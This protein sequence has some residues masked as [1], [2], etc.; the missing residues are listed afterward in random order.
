MNLKT[1]QYVLGNPYITTK[2]KETAILTCIAK[3]NKSFI[4]LLSLIKIR[5]DLKD[6]TIKEL[7]N[8]LSVSTVCVKEV[9][10]KSE[11]AKM[12]NILGKV[13]EFYKSNDFVEPTMR[14][15]WTRE[16]MIDEILRL[17]GDEFETKQDMIALAKETVEQ[18]KKR[19]TEIKNHN[20][21]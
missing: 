17:S 11:L 18:L 2:D 9:E 5:E 3:D 12:S 16:E 1:I 19:L 15:S 7:N 6:K 13:E 4:H 20:N 10:E 8:L 14:F 21:D